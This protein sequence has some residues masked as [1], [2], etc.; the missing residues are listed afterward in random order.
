MKSECHA[1]KAMAAITTLGDVLRTGDAH[2]MRHLF[3]KLTV[4]DEGQIEKITPR[5]W[6]KEPMSLM[7]RGLLI[8]LGAKNDPYG[9][10]TRV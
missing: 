4:G 9:T 7:K 3:E 1:D 2:A 5:G 6:A 10:R 8:G